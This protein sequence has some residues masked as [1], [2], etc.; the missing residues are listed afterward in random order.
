MSPDKPSPNGTANDGLPN[1]LESAW[2]A[3]APVPFGKGC[4]AVIYQS[5]GVAGVVRNTSLLD[6]SGQD[7]LERRRSTVLTIFDYIL[8]ANWLDNGILH[9][10]DIIK[11]KGQGVGECEAPFR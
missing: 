5:S 7:S 8:N 3:V 11:W 6:H 9:V 2:V 1:D 4:L 10:L